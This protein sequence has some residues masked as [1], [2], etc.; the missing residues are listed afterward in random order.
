[1][2]WMLDTRTYGLHIRY[3]TAAEGVISWKGD[4]ILY[5]QIQFNMQQIKG[6]VFRIV[7]E[8]RRTLV[9]DLLLLQLDENGDI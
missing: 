7:E 5:Q 3:Y 1:M 9:Q 4:T 8:A 6:M 2:D